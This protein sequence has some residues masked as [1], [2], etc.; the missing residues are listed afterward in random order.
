M[1]NSRKRRLFAYIFSFAM[2]LIMFGSHITAEAEENLGDSSPVFGYADILD[3]QFKESGDITIVTYNGNDKRVEIPSTIDGKTVI[4][5]DEFVF[6][7]HYELEEVVLPDTLQYIGMHA[8]S[9]TSISE[10]DIPEGVESI[11]DF[12]FMGCDN[13]KKITLPSTLKDISGAFYSNNTGKGCLEEINVSS[14]NPDFT[15]S[16]GIL[17]NKDK[18]ILM[19]FPSA[20]KGYYRIPESVEIIGYTAFEG[21]RLER[22]YIPDSVTKIGERA[23]SST[24][25]QGV[26]VPDTVETIGDNML[27][28]EYVYKRPILLGS[29]TSNFSEYAKEKHYDYV[30]PAGS[31]SDVEE[32]SFYYIP[33]LWASQAE[34]QITSGVGGNKFKPFTM[35]N[36]A[37]MITF[38]WKA[39]GCPGAVLTDNPFTDVSEDDFYFNAVMWAKQAGITSGKTA[40]EFDPMGPCSRGQFVIFLWRACGQ[41]IV[42]SESEF[43]DVAPG[44]DLSKAVS[45]ACKYGITS[46]VT[47]TKFKPSTALNRAQAVTFLCRARMMISLYDK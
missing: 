5:I 30:D 20:R 40:T 44:T 4:G 42:E 34:P 11:S 37:Q 43:S 1:R 23:F 10:I 46:G 13:L 6:W 28:D 19:K 8:F 9:M 47:A 17:F 36:R 21:S 41:E 24:E 29:K 14:A 26:F 3:Y 22:V 35:C 2:L 39:K 31:F 27:D 18:S 7:E 45:W 12:A 25:I 15:S 32:D 33:T 38:L 16:Y